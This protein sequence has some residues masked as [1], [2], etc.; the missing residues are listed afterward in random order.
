MKK[1]I[2][3]SLVVILT[4]LNVF[5][6]NKAE[7]YVFT[8]C[9]K[10]GDCTLSVDEFKKCKKELTLIDENV[11]INSFIVSM[12]VT[13]AESKEGIYVDYVNTGNVFNKETNEAIEKLISEKKLAVKILIEAVEISQGERKS[14]VPGMIINV[15]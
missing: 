1:K 4:T 14:K 12:L 15:K 5:A 11:K 2:M 7:K 9:G 10:T 6:Q 3:I 8:F 13:T